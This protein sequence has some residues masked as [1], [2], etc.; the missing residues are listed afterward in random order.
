MIGERVKY[1]NG[2]LYIMMNTT[3]TT[4]MAQK[5]GPSVPY[6][7]SQPFNLATFL[8]VFSPIIL[9]AMVISYSIFYQNAKGFVYLGFLLAM[10]VLRTI[11]LQSLGIEKH[12]DPCDIVRFTDYGNV[13]FT[14]FVFGFTLIYLLLPM[15]QSG[16][17]N[18]FLVAFLIFYVLFDIGIKVIRGCL[19]FSKQLSSIIG[20]FFAGGLLAAALVFAMYA[21]NSDRLLFFADQTANGVIC[22]RPKQQ[23]FRCNVFKNGE[24]VSS[25]TT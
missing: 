14:T 12:K 13:T 5:Y 22:S 25:S 19:D 3:T 17:I 24:L 21:G 4:N 8:S 23:T 9:I 6:I 10:V 2:L 1:N 20:D 15:F 7:I 16:V 18:W 11:V